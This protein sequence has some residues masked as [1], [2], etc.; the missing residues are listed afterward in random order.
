MKRTSA[1]T[2]LELLAVLV[3]LVALI[4]ILATTIRARVTRAR[5]D[6][7]QVLIGNLTQGLEGYHLDK[8][9]YPT[10]EQGLQALIYIPSNE[11]TARPMM[12]GTMPGTM[13]GAMPG[14][15]PFGGGATTMG[16]TSTGTSALD[17]PGFGAPGTAMP[18]TDPFAAPGTTMPGADPFAAPGTTMPGAD[19]FAAPGT[20]PGA[21]PGSTDPFGAPGGMPGASSLG[22]GGSMTG[23]NDTTYN[24]QLYAQLR[25]RPSPYLETNDDEVPLDAF[26]RP[27]RYVYAPVNGINPLTGNDKPAIWSAGPDGVDN[28]EDD[29]RNWDPAKVAQQMQQGIY[30]QGGVDPVTGQP[31]TTPGQPMPGQPDPFAP[32]QQPGPGFDTIPQP[33]PMPQPGPGFDTMPQ[34]TPMPTPM[35]EPTPMPPTGP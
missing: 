20:M 13:P 6:Q 18:G 33:T 1:F 35:P 25:K 7:T 23:W 29:I 30:G 5:S 24:P 32:Q 15:D 11:M 16:A 9:T 21:M 14:A 8:G 2:L 10:T 34:P 27:F 26:K 22:T 12:P 4:A 17:G 3:I 19:P 28:T 31:T